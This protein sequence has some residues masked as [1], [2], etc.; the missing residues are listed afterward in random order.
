MIMPAY[1]WND[2]ILKEALK[3]LLQRLIVRHSHVGDILGRKDICVFC[4]IRL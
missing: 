2:D 3:F 4:K 1:N